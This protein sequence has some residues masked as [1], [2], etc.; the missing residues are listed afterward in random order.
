MTNTS[1]TRVKAQSGEKNGIQSKCQ[2]R[3]A[4]LFAFSGRGSAV[5]RETEEER[6]E[7][8]QR[9]REGENKAGERNSNRAANKARECYSGGIVYLQLC[10]TQSLLQ[11]RAQLLC[12]QTARRR[13]VAD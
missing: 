5:W 8:R 4:S 1:F 12:R 2:G 11:Q 10:V 3:Q 9:S 13:R 7:N 6:E